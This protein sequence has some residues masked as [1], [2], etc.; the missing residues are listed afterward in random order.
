MAD[1]KKTRARIENFMIR[2]NGP[3]TIIDPLTNNV[4][5][6]AQKKEDRLP[7]VFLLKSTNG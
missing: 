4:S 2:R 5:A 3:L 7:A 6:Y 1:V